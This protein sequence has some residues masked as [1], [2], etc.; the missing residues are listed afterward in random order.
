MERGQ[1]R[2]NLSAKE[3]IAVG[4]TLVTALT[5]VGAGVAAGRYPKAP[6]YSHA[7]LEYFG[8]D[9]SGKL[10]ESQSEAEIRERILMNRD[11]SPGTTSKPSPSEASSAPTIIFENSPGHMLSGYER[12][13]PSPIPP[14]NPDVRRQQ[15]AEINSSTPLENILFA[16]ENAPQ[17]LDGVS[18]KQLIKDIKIYYP[19][20]KPI[21]DAY[22]L[23]WE[24]MMVTIEEESHASRSKGTFSKAKYPIYGIAQINVETWNSVINKTAK[25]FAQLATLPQRNP[26]DWNMIAAG[27]EIIYKNY[28]QYMQKGLGN[29]QALLDAL[30]LYTGSQSLADYRLS[31]IRK[32]EEVTPKS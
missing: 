18:N 5:G 24:V 19:I 23:P 9:S 3:R 31:Q 32:L 1:R 17:V 4:L 28:A 12:T 8:M 16:L 2:H 11:N 26:D 21:S 7:K 6:D 14:Q 13:S 30:I 20:I 15:L 27:T 10:I 25:R 29:N 22:G